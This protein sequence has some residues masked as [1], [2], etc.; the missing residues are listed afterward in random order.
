MVT[1]KAYF[2]RIVANHQRLVQSLAEYTEKTME[3]AVPDRELTAKGMELFQVFFTQPFEMMDGWSRKD[4]LELLQNDFWAVYSERIAKSTEKSADL[5]SRGLEF[6][7]LLNTHYDVQNQ[8]VRMRGV[9]DAFNAMM[10][11]YRHTLEANAEV[12]REYIEVK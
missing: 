2:D 10:E 7:R 8:H 6:I 9:H 1:T 3:A 11:S 4:Y 5:F 12:A